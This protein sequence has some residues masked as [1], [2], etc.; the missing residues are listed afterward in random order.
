M[1]KTDVQGGRPVIASRRE[2][3][4]GGDSERGGGEEGEEGGEGLGE[5]GEEGGRLG[6][7]RP[8]REGEEGEEGEEAAYDHDDTKSGANLKSEATNCTPHQAPF[9]FHDSYRPNTLLRE[10]AT[11]PKLLLVN[12]CHE[13]Q[14]EMPL[15][16]QVPKGLPPLK[17]ARSAKKK[18]AEVPVPV[19]VAD[20]DSDADEEDEQQE[21]V[22]EAVPE[23][24]EQKVKKVR[25]AKKA[26]PLEHQQ[27]Q[28]NQELDSLKKELEFAKTESVTSQK[29]LKQSQKALKEAKEEVAKLKR[30]MESE[31]RNAAAAM[32]AA[33]DGAP[34]RMDRDFQLDLEEEQS[35]RPPTVPFP[36][37]PCLLL[38]CT[39]CLDV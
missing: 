35:N 37:S 30:Q 1:E 26:Q 14:S 9:C 33:E 31:K 3:R 29:K 17:K 13:A 12:P 6:G 4:G 8:G 16:S 39:T 20:E 23:V 28:N 24:V 15:V 5:E 21:A 7:G 22:P 10:P 34:A 38:R 18:E 2:T 27:L 25:K 11:C 32:H 19:P 36:P